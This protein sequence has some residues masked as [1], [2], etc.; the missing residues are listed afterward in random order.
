MHGGS[1]LLNS[2]VCCR[3]ERSYGCVAL[4]GVRGIGSC[5][6]IVKHDF[7]PKIKSEWHAT[8]ESSS[9]GGV[10]IGSLLLRC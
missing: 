3:G 10:Q 7:N 9:F 8:L 5:R 2:D 6:I 4:K 1:H